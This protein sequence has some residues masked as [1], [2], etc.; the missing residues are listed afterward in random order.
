MLFGIG[1]KKM[2]IQKSYPYIL[3][4]GSIIGLLASF[5]LMLNTIELIKNP[6]ADLPCNLNPFISCGNAILS[7]AGEAFGFP[8]PLLGLISFS[9]L[10]ATGILL[11][12]GGRAHKIYYQLV[13]LGTLASTIFV[14]WFIYQS[15]FN[16]NSLCLY[17]VVA[18]SALAFGLPYIQKRAPLPTGFSESRSRAAEISRDIVSLSNETN[19]KVKA[20]SAE[21]RTALRAGF[22][23]HSGYA[24]AAPHRACE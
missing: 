14:V 8:N 7:E 15:L 24:D 9:M 21:H 23:R 17:C 11:F 5:F 20:L 12:A 22:L 19:D 6:A 13:N 16:L 3:I 2:T 18:L 1:I 10:L 4:V